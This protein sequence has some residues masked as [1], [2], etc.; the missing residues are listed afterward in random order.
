[1]SKLVKRL[2]EERLRTTEFIV[3]GRTGDTAALQSSFG[4]VDAEQAAIRP[5]VQAVYPNDPAVVGAHR[6]AEQALALLP[7]LRELV[8]KSDSPAATAVARY[9]EVI[10]QVLPLDAALLRGVNSTEVNGLSNALS[11]LSSARNEATLQQ[12]TIAAATS[13][14]EPT[15]GELAGLLASEARLVTSLNNYR[16]ALDTAQ[17]V[18][19]AE[20]IAGPANTD[21]SR[22]VD[23]LTAADPAR[24]LP[25]GTAV[26]A[27]K[28]YGDFL[29][30]LDGADTGIRDE[31]AS[32]TQ[33]ARSTSVNLAVINVAVLLA[34]LVIGAIIVGLIT[35][36]IISSLRTLRGSAL[37]VAQKS[38]PDAVARM[39]GGTVPDVN[40]TPVPVH[41]REEVGEVARAFDAVHAQAVR[42]AAEQATLQNTVNSM[43][44]NLSR[45]SQSLVDRQLQLIEELESNEQDPDQLAS[46]FRLD[47]LATRMRRNSENLLVLAGTDL[48]KRSTHH[49]P[50]VDVLQ[51]AVSEVEQY[52]RVTVEQP[53]AVTVLG[54]AANDLQHLLSE[55]L[56]NATSFSPPE[57]QVT[58]STSRAGNGPLV[59]EIIDRGIGM[60][61][62][63]LEDINRRFADAD[64]SRMTASRRMGLFVVGRL[65]ARHGVQVRLI[66][67]APTPARGGHRA[68]GHREGHRGDRPGHHP[69]PPGDQ[70]H[71]RRAPSRPGQQVGARAGPPGGRSAVDH[72]AAAARRQRPAAAAGVA[73]QCRRPPAQN[74]SGPGAGPET[75]PAGPTAIPMPALGASGLAKRTR[76]GADPEAPADPERSADD[77]APAAATGP[78]R[79]R[80]DRAPAG[81]TGPAPAGTTA[82]RG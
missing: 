59:V 24:P 21:R 11:G 67:G 64:D 33:A 8:L 17:R 47:H 79:P 34:A 70:R 16:T 31:L 65:A 46:L 73:G 4:E 5:I 66:A 68:G 61:P 48:A 1:M 20:L 50:I 27:S 18:R 54:R 41:T 80:P 32:T 40:V 81:S 44:V 25:G 35:R 36:A 7:Q 78:N 10:E 71:R 53:P 38:L 37:E 43:F 69:R 19:F 82:R 49:V 14:R 42:L 23:E 22:L 75:P 72:G 55:L 29:A 63:E 45:R 39:R 77:A 30:E 62:D 57:T 2:Q 6:Q 26:R 58:M 9:S 56:D 28:V 3:A 13:A 52:E 60:R 74:G 12:A 51:A 15:G 76:P